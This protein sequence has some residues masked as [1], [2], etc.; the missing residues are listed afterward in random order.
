MPAVSAVMIVRDAERT[1]DAALA[2]LAGF[3]EVLVYDNGS[4]DGT[5]AR[6]A[7]YPN[8]VL[9]K[10]PFVG[11]GPTKSRAVALAGRDWVLCIDADESVTPELMA[12][13]AAADLSDVRTMFAVRRH[14]Y[15]MGREVRHSGWADDW[16][17]RLFHRQHTGYDDAP[18]H[19]KVRAIA[20]GRVVRLAGA[21]RHDAVADIGDFLVK[22]NRYS[23]IRREQPLRLRSTGLILLRSCWAFFRTFVLRGGFLDG[24]RGAVIAVSDANG[25]FFKFMKVYADERVRREREHDAGTR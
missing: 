6:A 5:A 24:W 12:S 8:V 2:S 19:E 22:V 16:L 7:A 15:F 1:I 14:N 4:V 20:G 3:P 25:T 10:G 18:V 23:E 21:L 13:I 11:F 17:V 9:R